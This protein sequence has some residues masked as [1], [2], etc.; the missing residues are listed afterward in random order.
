MSGLAQ[1][2]W[3][4]GG[5]HNLLGLIGGNAADRSPSQLEG[6]KS[7]VAETTKASI[8]STVLVSEA[9]AIR[10]HDDTTFFERAK[11]TLSSAL[12]PHKFGL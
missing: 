10:Q 6:S 5:A 3:Y 9:K 4:R 12:P 11:Q 2:P 8:G 7:I 1:H